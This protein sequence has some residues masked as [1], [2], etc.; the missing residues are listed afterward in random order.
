MIRIMPTPSKDAE[1][2]QQVKDAAKVLG[3]AGWSCLLLHYSDGSLLMRP[4]TDDEK[5]MLKRAKEKK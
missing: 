3:E 4:L 1:S 5:A 2:I